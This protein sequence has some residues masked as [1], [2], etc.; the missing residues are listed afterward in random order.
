M[1]SNPEKQ[2]ESQ[3][4]PSP[5]EAPSSSS[6]PQTFASRMPNVPQQ[7][8]A[9]S[10]PRRKS[11]I[12]AM[13]LSLMPGLGQIYVGFYQQGFINIIVVASIIAVLTL[14][15][16]D[17][18]YPL[19]GL[20]LAFYWLYNVVDAGRRAAFYNQALDGMTDTPIPSEFKPLTEKGSIIGGAALVLLGIFFLAHT[21]FGMSLE[22]LEEWWPMALVVAGSFLVIQSWNSRKEKK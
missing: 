13:V 12:L 1:N 22:W 3:A 19:L 7:P 6:Q 5:F 10:D 11:P 15:L 17:Y 18:M 2:N 16:P 14:R 20:F 21:R 8:Y 4:E 9:G